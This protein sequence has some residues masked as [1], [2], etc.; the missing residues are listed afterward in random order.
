MKNKVSIY[1]AIIIGFMASANISADVVWY[2]YSMANVLDAN[3]QVRGYANMKNYTDVTMDSVAADVLVS[4]TNISN[5]I[6]GS[7]TAPL[8]VIE[9]HTA[10]GNTTTW[11]INENVLFQV[12][13]GGLT[14]NVMKSGPAG[15]ALWVITNA[16]SVTFQ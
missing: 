13:P 5:I 2:L 14:F 7:A 3:L 12:V 8:S 9:Y 6:S 10:V 15:T 16:A 4:F 11:Q 1:S